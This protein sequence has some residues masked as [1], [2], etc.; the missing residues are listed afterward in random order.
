[1]LD[2]RSQL[3]V[4]QSLHGCDKRDHKSHCVGCTLAVATCAV[5]GKQLGHLTSPGCKRLLATL[6]QLRNSSRPTVTAVPLR[7]TPAYYK[8]MLLEY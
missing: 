2:A 1:M 5:M 3:L 6:H 8:S 7:T 4:A